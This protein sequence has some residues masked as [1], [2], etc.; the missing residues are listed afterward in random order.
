MF[1]NGAVQRNDSFLPYNAKYTVS[2]AN[3]IQT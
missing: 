2:Y 1:E 3:C